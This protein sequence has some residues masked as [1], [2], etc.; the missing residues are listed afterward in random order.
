VYKKSGNPTITGIST[1]L[2][3]TSRIKLP[4]TEIATMKSFTFVLLL[5]VFVIASSGLRIPLKK[6]KRTQNDFERRL[7]C[8]PVLYTNPN[9]P[10]GIT[11]PFP[12]MVYTGDASPHAIH[13]Y[14][15]NLMDA[16]Y[17]G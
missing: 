9:S 14:L 8:N 7:L 11:I 6:F 17:Y 2:G 15:E 10:F 1:I 13:E 4:S 16:Q 3:D 5:A 12:Q